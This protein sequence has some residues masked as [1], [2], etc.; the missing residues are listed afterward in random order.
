MDVLIEHFRRMARYNRVANE[1]LYA[2]VARLPRDAFEARRPA[3][4]GSIRGTLNHIV[5]G[6]RIWLTRFAGEVAASTDLDAIL[7]PALDDLRVARIAEDERIDTMAEG[8]TAEFL[9]SD[10]TYVANDG[11]EMTDPANVAVAH[12]FNHQTHHRGQVHNMLSQTDVAPPSLDMHRCLN[13]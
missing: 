13:P 5:V 4:F 7:Y 10:L 12:F 8:L 1:R 3:F 9:A 6:D 2:A 11:R